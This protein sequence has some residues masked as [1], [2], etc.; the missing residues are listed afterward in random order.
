MV[1]HSTQRQA[2]GDGEQLLLHDRRHLPVAV[3]APLK[4][5]AGAGDLD[6]V[7][8]R[9]AA[10]SRPQ[11]HLQ[12]CPDTQVLGALLVVASVQGAGVGQ[13]AGKREV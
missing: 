11:V 9:G 8:H 4:V 13:G 2:E 3:H 5:E 1:D 10:L 7:A 6:L 12:L